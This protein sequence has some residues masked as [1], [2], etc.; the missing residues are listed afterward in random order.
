ME[1]DEPRRT[2][3]PAEWPPRRIG[4]PERNRTRIGEREG[5]QPA[6]CR[7]AGRVV[8]GA[9]WYVVAPGDTLQQIAV[10]HYGSHRAWRR[11]LQ[12]RGW[13]DAFLTGAPFEEFLTRDR[14]D[15]EGVLKDLGL[16]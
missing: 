3:R 5:D 12:D 7:R 2:E 9:G 6:T 16:A 1:R 15:T 13:D 11:I 4:G 10:A 8:E 14:A